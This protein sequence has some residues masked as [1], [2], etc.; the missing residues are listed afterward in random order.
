MSHAEHSGV[1][2]RQ[3][4]AR[5]G[6][7]AVAAVAG[8]DLVARQWV[9][10]AAAAENSALAG[11]PPLDGSLVYDAASLTANAHDQGNIVFRRPCAVLRP[12]SVQDVRKMVAFCA[13]HGIKVAPA[14]AHHAMFGQP[15]VSGAWSSRCGRWTPSTR[16]ARTAPTSRRACCGR[17][18]SGP[19]S[20]RG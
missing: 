20:P 11:V 10:E 5:F 16:S 17:T 6:A 1:G 13:D 15:L 19:P 9:T 3:F 12:G 8:F 7:G 2:R 4:L 18:W 14:G